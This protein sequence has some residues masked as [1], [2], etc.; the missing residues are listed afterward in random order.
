MEYGI[1]IE[2]CDQ[3]D[4]KIN[5][6]NDNIDEGKKILKKNYFYDDKNESDDDNEY[7]DKHNKNNNGNLKNSFKKKFEYRIKENYKVK[8]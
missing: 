6:K 2:Y 1:P 3:K 4:L 8:Y 7:D 5:N